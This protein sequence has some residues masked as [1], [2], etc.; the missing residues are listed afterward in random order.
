MPTFVS[1]ANASLAAAPADSAAALAADV[2]QIAGRDLS[3]VGHDLGVG[4]RRTRLSGLLRCSLGRQSPV[5]VARLRC[6]VRHGRREA[7]F[8]GVEGGLSLL[9]NSRWG[10]CCLLVFAQLLL[11]LSNLGG[12][13]CCRFVRR[14]GRARRLACAAES[15]PCSSALVIRSSALVAAS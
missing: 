2:S 9:C 4:Q 13:L 6:S 8:G 15:V 1:L 3:V 5:H 10:A 14:C 12:C 11:V 7:L